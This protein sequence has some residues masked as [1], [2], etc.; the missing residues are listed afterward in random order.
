MYNGIGLTSARGSGTNGYVTRNLGHVRRRR[1]Q[2]G[3]RPP[4]LSA[5][6]QAHRKPNKEIL[7]HKRKRQVEVKC[8][9]LRVRMEEQG[10]VAVPAADVLPAGDACDVVAA[11]QIR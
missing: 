5:A 8:M 10:C 7:E 4:D 3:Y 11:V 2:T 9:E 6:P 1:K